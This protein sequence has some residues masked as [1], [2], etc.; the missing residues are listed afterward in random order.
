MDSLRSAK[1]T[2]ENH[3]HRSDV[4]LRSKRLGLCHAIRLHSK[5]KVQETTAQK[6]AASSRKQVEARREDRPEADDG[7]KTVHRAEVFLWQ[8]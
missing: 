5:T 7:F 4:R 8:D 6:T 3:R 1:H 2:F